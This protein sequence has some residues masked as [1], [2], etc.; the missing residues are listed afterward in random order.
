MLA[1][2]ERLRF[3]RSAIRSKVRIPDSPSDTALRCLMATA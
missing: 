1:R 2:S 3:Q